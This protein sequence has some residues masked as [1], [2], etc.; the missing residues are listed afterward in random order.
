MDSADGLSPRGRYDY[1]QALGFFLTWGADGDP[2]SARE[3][4]LLVATGMTEAGADRPH[5]AGQGPMSPPRA[6]RPVVPPSA[7]A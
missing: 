7:H 4:A 5:V 6:P 1:E 2:R 3:H